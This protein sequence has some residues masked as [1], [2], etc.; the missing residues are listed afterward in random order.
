MFMT[1]ASKIL[2]SFEVKNNLNPKI[3]TRGLDG[4]FTL[5]PDIR[6]KLLLVTNDFLDF[7]N[8]DELAIETLN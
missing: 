8:L 4:E 5:R 1:L 2:S 7:I 6:K 3:W